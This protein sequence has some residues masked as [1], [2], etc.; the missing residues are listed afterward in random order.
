MW[1]SQHESLYHGLSFRAV[2]VSVKGPNGSRKDIEMRIL[3][4]GWRAMPGG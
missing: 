3:E 2:D 4:Q 1:G